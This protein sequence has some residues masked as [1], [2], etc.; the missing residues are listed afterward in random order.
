MHITTKKIRTT[1]I[2]NILVIG[3]SACSSTPAPWAQTDDSPWTSK[4]EAEQPGI[5]AEK[6]DAESLKDPVLLAD[7]DPMTR[8]VVLEQPAAA[9]KPEVI[10]EP[11]IEEK[12]PEQEILAMPASNYAVQVYAGKTIANM[13]K[14]KKEK[15]LEDLMSVRTDRNGH[16]FYVLVDIH[17]DRAS[18]K[19][20]AGYLQKKT[21]SKPWIRSVAGLQKIISTE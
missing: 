15:G 3:L 10:V 12:T 2:V 18:A 8:S 1:A 4:H 16:I 7:P 6:V 14:Y 5:P 21:G 20:A 11:V 17:P 19:Q 9:P 13:D